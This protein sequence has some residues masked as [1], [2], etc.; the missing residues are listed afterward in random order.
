VHQVLRS[1]GQPLDYATRAYFEPRFEEDFSPVRVH[2]DAQANESAHSVNA[3][4]YTVGQDAVFGT[5]YYAPETMPGR[6]L[7]AHELAHVTQQGHSNNS[8]KLTISPSESVLEHQADQPAEVIGA[9]R[10]AAEVSARSSTSRLVQRY[11]ETMPEVVPESRLY[12]VPVDSDSSQATKSD[13]PPPQS[14]YDP[15]LGTI[16]AEVYE[17]HVL[18]AIEYWTERAAN[19]DEIIMVLRC[20]MPDVLH[21]IEPQHAEA[22]R[23]EL[24]LLPTPV[25]ENL[26]KIRDP[27]GKCGAPPGPK[28][29]KSGNGDWKPKNWLKQNIL[30]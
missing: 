17:F 10:I 7:L 20:Y 30:H 12:P 22:P 9:R 14:G 6:K 11:A 28:A 3:L 4:A 29:L 23:V 18:D 19:A 25:D 21:A 16:Y 27:G 26:I 1:P 15:T 5:G 8:T 2:S 24:L 13:R